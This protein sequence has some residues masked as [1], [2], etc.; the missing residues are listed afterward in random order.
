MSKFY[1]GQDGELISEEIQKNFNLTYKDFRKNKKFN[2][3][4]FDFVGVLIQGDKQLVVFPKHMHSKQELLA[5]QNNT[6]AGIQSLKLVMDV[7][8]KYIL[9]Q[10][11]RATADDYAGSF[12]ESVESTFPFEAFFGVYG[13][14]QKYGIFT[15]ERRKITENGSGKYHWKSIIEKSQP[16]ITSSGIVFSPLYKEK[17]ANDYTFISEAMSYVINETIEKFYYLLPYSRVDG[18]NYNVSEFDDNQYVLQRLSSILLRTF[19]DIDVSLINDLI[20]FF[21]DDSN[22]YSPKDQ[23]LKVHYFNNI[24]QAM[25]HNYLNR[26]FVKIEQGMPIFSKDVIYRNTA[27][28]MNKSLVIDDS[29]NRWSIDMDHYHKDRYYQ[30]IFDSKYYDDEEGLNYKQISYHEIM[31]KKVRDT[32]IVTISALIFPGTDRIALHYKTANSILTREQNGALKVVADEVVIF[33]FWMNVEK[34]MID[35]LRRN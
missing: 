16:Y 8:T 10:K 17:V 32:D 2:D 22:K 23:H 33:S 12:E 3:R 21:E 13:Y 35:Y 1:F 19:K 24:W 18:I 25:V 30:L 15:E 6:D 4:I 9:T 29:S 27:Y 31:T 28:F 14:F 20:V 26:H 5:F 11:T 34:V 7:I